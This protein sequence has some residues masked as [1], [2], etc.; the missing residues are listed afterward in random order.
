M[1]V[2]QKRKNG[3]GFS[4]RVQIR[5]KGTEIYKSFIT[6]EDAKLYAFY[7]ERLIDNMAAFDVPLKLRVN[8]RQIIELKISS[9]DKTPKRAAEEFETAYARVSKYI[10][11]NKFIIDI[12]MDDWLN[13]AK[14]MLQDDVFYGSKTENG[15]RKMSLL[16]LRRYFANIS[17]A[18]SY[19]QSQGIEIDNLP[20]KVIQTYINPKIKNKPSID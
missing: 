6:E 20:L 12:S 17:S 11:E 15:K 18:I 10:K 8:L 1:A 19:A 14:S 13:I 4:Y 2:I 9:L 16:T 3:D 7:K 5:K